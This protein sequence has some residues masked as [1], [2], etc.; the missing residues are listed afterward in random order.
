MNVFFLV[1]RFV[2]VNNT[3]APGFRISG[4]SNSGRKYCTATAQTHR[5]YTQAYRFY[6]IDIASLDWAYKS[7]TCDVDLSSTKRR[8]LY[9]GGQI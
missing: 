4:M 2:A 8:H 7:S 9:Y 5:H 1:V 6:P 3:F